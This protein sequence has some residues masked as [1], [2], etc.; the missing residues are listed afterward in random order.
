MKIT[1]RQFCLKYNF[2]IQLISSLIKYG[3]IKSEK[4][5]YNREYIDEEILDDLKEGV[6]Y[7]CCPR[8][9]KK[10]ANVTKNHYKSCLI[11]G[12]A[13]YSLY[14]EIFK[15]HS[16]KSEESKKL[17]S[18]VLKERFKTPEGELTRKIIGENSRRINNDSDFF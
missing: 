14:S 12:D 5:S 15:E 4:V 2:E 7:V 18:K 11:F 10:M 13:N 8:C 17:Q 1:K 3:I 9:K 16:K 6:H